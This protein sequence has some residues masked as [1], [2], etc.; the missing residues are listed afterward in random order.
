MPPKY[1]IQ[2]R[3]QPARGKKG[4]I[5]QGTIVIPGEF[6][7]QLKR[8]ILLL[9]ASEAGNKDGNLNEFTS[10]LDTLR[11]NK[12]LSKKGYQILLQRFRD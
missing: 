1:N 9:G 8:M 10:I 3:W 5:G 12:K 2:S 4:K 6:N 7:E 11:N